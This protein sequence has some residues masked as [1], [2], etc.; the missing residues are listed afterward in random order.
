M[1]FDL[2]APGRRRTIKTFYVFLA[3][4]MGGGLIFFGI[5][6]NTA[7]GLLDAFNGNGGGGSSGGAVT[8]QVKQAERRANRNPSDPAAWANLAHVRYQ[9]AN[10]EGFNQAR[11]QYTAKGLQDLQQAGVAWQKYLGLDPAHPD[12]DLANLMVHAYVYLNQAAPAERAQRIVAAARPSAN[13]YAALAQYAYLAGDTGTGDLAAHKA[14]ALAP[15]AQK[16]Q[17]KTSLAAIKKQAKAQASGSSST[18][19]A[20]G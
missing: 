6:G 18:T 12:P 8:K 11:Q 13:A 7:G 20:G 4:L 19:A 9:L 10:N 1:L 2:R 3:L 17:L 16:A 14:L 15:K 5:G